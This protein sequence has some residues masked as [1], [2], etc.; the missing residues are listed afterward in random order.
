MVGIIAG[1]VLFNAETMQVAFIDLISMFGLNDLPL[2]SGE[3]IYYLKSYGVTFLMAIFGSTPYVRNIYHRVSNSSKGVNFSMIL[4]PIG[5]VC[6]LL[7]ITGYLVDG[8]FN[9]FLY[10]RF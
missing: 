4:E 8:S 9:P 1:F 6:L 7:V 10:F 3:S 5:L 2:F